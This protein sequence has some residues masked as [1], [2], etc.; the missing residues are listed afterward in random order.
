MGTLYVP[1][2]CDVPHSDRSG[3]VWQ[4]EDCLRIWR[5][6]EP[7]N[8]TYAGWYRLG[9]FLRWRYRRQIREAAS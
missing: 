9:R 4:C 2:R 1:H 6:D 8:P 3:V 5:Y 7:G